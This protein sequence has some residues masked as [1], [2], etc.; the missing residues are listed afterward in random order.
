MDSLEIG[1]RYS[2]KDTRRRLLRDI[3]I[4]RTQRPQQCKGSG[5]PLYTTVAWI[6]VRGMKRALELEV[7][8]TIITLS[9][10]ELIR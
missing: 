7:R 8:K 3:R 6:Y 9:L 10:K 5:T 4:L 1:G 2:A